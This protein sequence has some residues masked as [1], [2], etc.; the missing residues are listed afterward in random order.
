MDKRAEFNEA[1]K[2]A[3]KGKDQVAVSTIRLILAALKDRDI[4]A[5]SQGHADGIKDEEILAMLS[6]MVKQRKES[7]ETYKNAKR[8]ELAEQEEQEIHVIQR[9]MPRKLKR[10]EI[11]SAIDKIIADQGAS[12]I[13]DMGKVMGVLKKDYAGQVDMGEA[14]AIVK[15]KLSS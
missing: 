4:A 2:E 8:P 3:I 13:K 5:R 6:T 10:E 1:L 12:D 7:V 15:Q 9:F 14:S 11:E